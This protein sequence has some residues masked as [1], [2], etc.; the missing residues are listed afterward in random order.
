MKK[1]PLLSI[2]I[3]V[4]NTEPYLRCCLDAVLSQ[5]YDN[6]EVICVNDGSTDRS[7]DI[8][9]EYAAK[10]R[11]VVVITQIN[12]GQAAARCA[13]FDAARGEWIAMVDSDDY[14]EPDI[15]RK[16]IEAADDDVD[17]VSFNTRVVAEDDCETP[18]DLVQYLALTETGKIPM[19]PDVVYSTNVLLWNKLWRRS[20]ITKY[21]VPMPPNHIHE[22]YV[23]ALTYMAVARNLYAMKDIGYNYRI[24]QG[25]LT[26]GYEA[27]SVGNLLAYSQSWDYILKF[28]T[29]HGLLD[30][31]VEMAQ[32]KLCEFLV[33][34]KYLNTEADCKRA[35]AA[36]RALF[37]KYRLP[38]ISAPR[39]EARIRQ[40]KWRYK[41]AF[42]NRRKTLKARYRM[43]KALPMLINKNTSFVQIKIS[44]WKLFNIIPL[45]SI[46]QKA[47]CTRV[48]LFG[49][50]L[51]YLL[52][53][54]KKEN[55]QSFYLFNFLPI[56]Q[57][58]TK[59]K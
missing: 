57:I 35:D 41:L 24:R 23:F 8:L 4:Y 20:V 27:H 46:K 55:K 34:C 33:S 25:S 30:S 26:R 31:L 3:P 6:L 28:Y 50:S 1:Q 16:A 38:D 29:E 10:D 18:S 37:S 49:L 36:Y 56:L 2:I 47:D 39:L 14:P 45:I 42:G 48:Y 43:L 40:A 58:R 51:L 32:A 13:G 5:S 21:K 52:K 53:I 17:I 15:Y 44:T 9:A 59:I 11:R 19:T 12:Q 7:A 54:S 22:D